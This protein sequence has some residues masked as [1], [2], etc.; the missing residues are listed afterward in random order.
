MFGLF[1]SA[2]IRKKRETGYEK[3][4]KWLRCLSARGRI[5]KK[6]GQNEVVCVKIKSLKNKKT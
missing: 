3:E 2:K 4:K 1:Q 6:R 5:L